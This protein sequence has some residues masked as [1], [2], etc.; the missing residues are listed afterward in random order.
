M[1]AF[2][3]SGAYK[4]LGMNCPFCH[5]DINCYHR[6]FVWQNSHS[7]RLCDSDSF[8]PCLPVVF[9]YS[10]V[11][12]VVYS[13]LLFF[14]DTRTCARIGWDVWGSIII[15]NLF[16]PYLICWF[17]RSHTELQINLSE[18]L[19][20]RYFVIRWF[21][22]SFA[23]LF[24]LFLLKDCA[25]DI[26]LLWYKTCALIGWDMIISNLSGPY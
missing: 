13:T 26:A 23:S 24:P 19:I 12:R 3:F 15:S 11:F 8:M 16:E 20:V 21:C 10:I 17:T 18:I 25:L 1:K 2:R 7:P 9:L 22:V 6:S 4:Y 5:T 14:Y